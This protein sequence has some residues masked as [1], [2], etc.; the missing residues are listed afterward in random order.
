MDSTFAAG[1]MGGSTSPAASAGELLSRMAKFFEKKRYPLMR[2]FR[3]YDALGK[4]VLSMRSFL[5]AVES[6]GFSI[7]PSEKR[8]LESELSGALDA[9]DALDYDAFITSLLE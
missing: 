7:S 2:T 3:L 5:N 4:G 9:E 1:S 8:L 6:C